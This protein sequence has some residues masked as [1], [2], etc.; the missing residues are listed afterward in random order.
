[1]GYTYNPFKLIHAS[2]K[3]EHKFCH[4]QDIIQ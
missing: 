4:F 2:E 1:M 3:A